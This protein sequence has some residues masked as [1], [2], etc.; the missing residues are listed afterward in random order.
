[1]SAPVVALEQVED[2]IARVVMQDHENKNVFSDVLIEGL[3]HAFEQVRADTSLRVVILTGYDHY[4]C[5]GGSFEGLMTLQEGRATFADSNLYSLA[6]DCEIP[7]IAAMQGHGIGGGLVL[8]L[9]ADLV[10]MARES[11][12][13]ANFMKYGFTPGMGATF[14]LPDRLG[15]ALG[16]EMLLSA[17]NYRGED[18]KQ[19]GVPFPVLPRGEVPAEALERARELAEKPRR[20]LVTLKCHLTARRR[21]RLPKIIEQELAMH[22]Q[23]FHE[24]EV[25]ERIRDR[26]GN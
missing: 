24:D 11:V 7:V 3:F 25:K 2:G 26:F 23:T 20:A 4:F 12:Y 9:Y 17:R 21:A 14:I 13:T 6:L 22:E 10:I 15:E 1:V 18:L 8:G 16:E 5:S 19:R